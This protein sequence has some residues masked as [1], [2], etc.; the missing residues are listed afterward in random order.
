MVDRP[1]NVAAGT[2]GVVHHQRNAILV[3]DV[4]NGFEIGNREARVADGLDVDRLG[5]V[6][7]GGTECFRLVAIDKLDVDPEARQGHLELV[8]GAAIE[9][10]A[11]DDVVARL[12]DGRDGQELRR[13]AGTGGNRRDAPFEGGNAL[14]EDV[15]GRIHDPRVDI[16]ELLQGKQLRTVIGTVEGIGR[17]LVD[18]HGAG[19]GARCRLLAGMNLQGFVAVIA[20]D[21]FAHG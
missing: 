13:L 1:G 10:A 7:D 5:L 2:E 11:G 15:G 3:G 17:G 8:I 21:V 14:L 20:L 12:G 18:R 16:A 19:I 6:V 4:R 9:V